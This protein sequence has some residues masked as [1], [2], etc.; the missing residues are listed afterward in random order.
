MCAFIDS[1]S[2]SNQGTCKFLGGLKTTNALLV[3]LTHYLSPAF[4]IHFICAVA[5]FNTPLILIEDIDAFEQAVGTPPGE[6]NHLRAST[7]EKA[8]T[9]FME[10]QLVLVGIR[11]SSIFVAQG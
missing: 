4:D 8:N 11:H 6:H 10:L 7:I 1:T 5:I 3:H 2:L 9:G